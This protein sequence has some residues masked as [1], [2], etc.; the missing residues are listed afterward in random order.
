M[1]TY[2]TLNDA[3][4]SRRH[5][6]NPVVNLCVPCARGTYNIQHEVN[7]NGK[8]EGRSPSPQ[9]RQVKPAVG[10]RFDNDR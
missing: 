5:R 7:G 9:S 4:Q 1:N 6:T 3:R 2:L 8:L 10:F